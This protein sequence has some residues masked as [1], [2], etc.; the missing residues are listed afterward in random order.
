MLA[1][2]GLLAACMLVPSWQSLAASFYEGR[3]IS[4]VVG[5]PAGGGYDTYARFLARHLGKHVAGGP[6]VIVENRP[7]AASAISS[8]YV[9][10]IAP[11]DGTVICIS[12]NMLPLYQTLFP[13]KVNLDVTKIQFIGNMA[14]LTSV[15]AVSDRSPVKTIAGMT[16]R[17]AT[18]GS[19]GILSETYIIP[20]VL[21]HFAGAKFKV[22]LGFGGTSQMD[23]A[24]ERGELDGRGGLWS[25]FVV[26]R[27][28]WIKSGKIIPVLQIGT[29][30]DQLMRGV[31]QLM[32]LAT[33]EEQR[34]IYSILSNQPRLSRAFWVAP[35]VPADRIELLRKAF[36]DTMKDP[37]LL[38]ETTKAKLE[39]T[40][41]TPKD[42]QDA[43][44]E[45]ASTPKEY[46]QVL[47]DILKDY[48]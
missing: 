47:R 34:A 10:R 7:G 35:E 43:I 11:K 12:T 26:G 41:T 6:R 45:L 40:P 28:D 44:I 38:A 46:L 14:T 20:T 19:N 8:A 15:I 24:I 42:V 27:P 13:D 18:L 33:S 2:L 5:V 37:E 22:V 36:G 48:N 32:S 4:I 17:S 9:Y 31:P 39:I 16:Q 30:D 23:L 21:N 25:S 1:R 3:T 29:E